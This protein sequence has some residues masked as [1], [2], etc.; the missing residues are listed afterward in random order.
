MA[1]KTRH[2]YYGQKT[3]INTKKLL[4]TSKLLSQITGQSVQPNKAIVGKNAFAHEAGIHQ[5]GILSKRETYEIMRAE[6]VGYQKNALVLG[7]HSGRNALG[8]RLEEL[9]IKVSKEKLDQI[10]VKFKELADKKKN[11]YDEDLVLIAKEKTDNQRFELVDAMTISEK[12]NKSKAYVK[13]RDA[14]KIM[15]LAGTGDGT[16]SALYSAILRATDMSGNLT[17]F[18]VRSLTP[19]KDAV[20]MVN[21]EW[22]D[23]KGIV[24]SGQ[25]AN[26]DTTIA[27][28]EALIDIMNRREIKKKH[29]DK[30]RS[31]L[32][33]SV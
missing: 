31:E 26:T 3:N 20:G 18:N 30:K 15:E 6:D 22:T 27:A 24:W 2:D 17:Y 28:G 10:F 14:K 29:I 25:G 9:G 13:V 32:K 1:L 12:D 11:I 19:E 21:I 4:A 5:H 7:K 33:K 16:V 23:E 8:N